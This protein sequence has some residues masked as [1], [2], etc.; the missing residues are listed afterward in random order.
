MQDKDF[1]VIIVGAGI[2]GLSAG[3]SFVRQGIRTIILEKR[4]QIGLKIRGEVINPD[5]PIFKTIFREGLPEEIIELWYDEAYYYSPSCQK[6]AVRLFKERRRVNVNYRL[7]IEKLAKLA[8]EGGAQLLMNAEVTD[9]SH[10]DGKGH[11]IQVLHL[12]KKQILTASL[13]IGADGCDSTVR[14]RVGLPAPKQVQLIFKTLAEQITLENGKRLEFFLLTTP[15]AVLWIFPKSKTS[16]EV[17][18][19]LWKPYTSEDD[20]QALLQVWEKNSEHHPLFKERIAQAWFIYQ[21]FD[22]LP[23]GGPSRNHFRP[24][25]FLIGDA[26]GQVGAVGGS[27]IITSLT[28]GTLVGRQLGS[29][30]KKA[31]RIT[32]EDLSECASFLRKSEIG[33]YLLKEKKTAKLMRDVLYNILKTPEGIDAKWDMFKGPI[34]SR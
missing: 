7:L 24:H 20:K 12:N 32:E 17:G 6:V 31:G 21:D 19:T 29:T 18:C 28:I 33:K 10:S 34:E 27:G 13:V 3:L 5:D 30:L 9:V 1:D 25:V 16:A 2:A 26:A 8:I 11:E 14:K 15:P 23:F 22:F 4:A